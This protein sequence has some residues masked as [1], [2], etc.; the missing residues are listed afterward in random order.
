[1]TAT[2]DKNAFYRRVVIATIL[3]AAAVLLGA[4]LFLLFA[5]EGRPLLEIGLNLT[6]TTTT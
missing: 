1:M 3:L 5:R 4:V 2:L 6:Q